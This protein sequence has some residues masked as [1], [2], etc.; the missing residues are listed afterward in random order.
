MIDPLM[1]Q[2]SGRKIRFFFT[3]VK[4]DAALKMA[5]PA[6]FELYF[7]IGGAG[8]HELVRELYV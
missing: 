8:F 1:C 6:L 4:N 3:L 7:L 2:F 5:R